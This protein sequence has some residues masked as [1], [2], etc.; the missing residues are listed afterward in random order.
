MPTA[1]AAMERMTD[2]LLDELESMARQWCNTADTAEL[3]APA[4][5]GI[6]DSGGISANAGALHLLAEHGRFRIEREFG[7]M[8]L[9]YWP[10]NEQFKKT[11][12]VEVSGP[13]SGSA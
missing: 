13:R 2:D 10:E 11:P 4:E 8:V 9:G 12:N 1:I 3:D 5:P 6:T 7:R